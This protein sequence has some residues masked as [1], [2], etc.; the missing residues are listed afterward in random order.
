MHCRLEET[1]TAQKRQQTIEP[2]VERMFILFGLL[3]TKLVS[4]CVYLPMSGAWQSGHT[5]V[6][7]PHFPVLRYLVV[8]GFLAYLI[9]FGFDFLLE[10]CFSFSSVIPSFPG[11]L[12]GLERAASL[13]FL[14]VFPDFR[15]KHSE[16]KDKVWE[17]QNYWCLC[18][19]IF[20]IATELL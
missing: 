3:A 9:S 12:T 2:D 7:W 14:G 8:F 20:F 5:P 10:S 16:T 11:I 6:S 4:L 13:G 18:P 19:G 15:T 17:E 1:A